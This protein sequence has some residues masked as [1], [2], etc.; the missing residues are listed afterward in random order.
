MDGRRWTDSDTAHIC[1]RNLMVI[2]DRMD[3][4]HRS[5]QVT[6]PNTRISAR[7]LR[8]CQTAFLGT[9]TI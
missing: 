8:K 6:E 7:G 1:A 9:G 5:S 2:A 3:R 4:G